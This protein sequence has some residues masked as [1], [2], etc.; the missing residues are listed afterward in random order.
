M[1]GESQ[2]SPTNTGTSRLILPFIKQRFLIKGCVK[3]IACLS[4]SEF[5]IFSN[6]KIR[7]LW[8]DTNTNTMT[9]SLHK[10]ACRKGK[11]LCP[12][13]AKEPLAGCNGEGVQGGGR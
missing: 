11:L 13:S 1:F 7:N 10:K 8:G 5:A 6:P 4:V 9:F 2:T 3:K 12:H